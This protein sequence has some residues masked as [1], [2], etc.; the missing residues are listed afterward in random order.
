[1]NNKHCSQAVHLAI[2]V[3]FGALLGEEPTREQGR[4][5]G[6]RALWLCVLTAFL[7]VCLLL[8]LEVADCVGVCVFVLPVIQFSSWERGGEGIHSGN[9]K[10]G[11]RSGAGRA[12]RPAIPWL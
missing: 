5:W 4:G 6:W 3:G 9:L 2:G 1:M 10:R 11:G 8:P 7:P 12:W